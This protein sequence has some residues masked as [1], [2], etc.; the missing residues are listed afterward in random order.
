ML[1]DTPKI[2][3]QISGRNRQIELFAVTLDTILG[4]KGLM[5]AL[6]KI[7]KSAVCFPYHPRTSPPSCHHFFYIL[8]FPL[9]VK[10]PNS[11]LHFPQTSLK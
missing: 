7:V 8:Q 11:A 3:Q 2:T 5:M 10:K 1:S 9:C 6:K 4:G